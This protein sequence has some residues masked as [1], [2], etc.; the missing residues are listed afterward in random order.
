VRSVT[1]R[2]LHTAIFTHG[3]VDHVNG[4]QNYAAESRANGWPTPRVIAH[5]ATPR[6]FRRYRE[7]AIWNGY[8]NL[9]QFRGGQGEPIFPE[10]F[11]YP[12]ITY[13]GQMT[14]S[15]GGVTAE[16]YHARGETDDH[17][18]IFFPETKVL[19]TG[20]LFIYAVPNAGNPQKV[21]RYCREWATALR[22]MAALR[23]E[24]LAPGHGFLIIGAARVQQALMDTAEYLDSLHEQTLALMNKGVSLDTVIHSVK[25]PEALV[26]KPYLRPVYDEPEFI[27][28]NIWRLYGGWYDGTPS[29]LKPA[30]EKAQAEEIARLAGGVDKLA[31]RAE[32]LAAGG[33][34]RLA[35][36]LIDWASLAAP[37][38]PR[39]KEAGGRVYAARAKVE[40]STMANGI[41]RSAAVGFGQTPE[42]P[43]LIQSVFQL[44]RTRT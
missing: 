15:V 38:D 19:S 3:H 18:W 41:Y 5:E 29:H 30:P 33:D 20:D 36:H 6:R 44:Q 31:A 8:I 28:R 22:H 43:N 23:P 4:V 34:F 32:E 14:L 7:S 40:P 26:D 21:Q 17:T 11:Y 16:L 37:D 25:P 10:D 9:R 12:D 13:S 42:G 24:V 27:V 39:V 2:N 35:C 1:G